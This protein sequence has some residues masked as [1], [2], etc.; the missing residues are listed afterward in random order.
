MYR[1][2]AM[3]NI[4]ACLCTIFVE[5]AILLMQ[6]CNKLA[7]SFQFMS[8]CCCGVLIVYLHCLYTMAS[9]LSNVGSLFE[10]KSF[11]GIGFDLWRDRMQNIL[12]FKD[13][14]GTL[15]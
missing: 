8:S 7:G 12:F 15:A 1:I 2:Y 6:R 5:C 14:D 3:M 4:H 9:S 10:I 13:C 11:E